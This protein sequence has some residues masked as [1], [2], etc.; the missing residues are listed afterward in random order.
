MELFG[1]PYDDI[2]EECD[3]LREAG[4]LGVK[5]TPPNEHLFDTWIEDEG[6]NPWKYFYINNRV[7][8]EGPNT[9][10]LKRALNTREASP[11]ES[12][13]RLFHHFLTLVF[14][15][16]VTNNIKQKNHKE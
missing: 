14:T 13:L 5:I 2:T 7:I 8:C 9:A 12:L 4:Y 10:P 6:M 16:F 1:W 3:F 15:E 11:G